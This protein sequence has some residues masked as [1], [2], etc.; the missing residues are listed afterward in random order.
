[1][2][3]EILRMEQVVKKI[4][5]AEALKELCLTIYG[6]EILGLTGL[7]G[8]GKSVIAE[9]LSGRS[10]FDRG[11]V[12]LEH[13]AAE[14]GMMIQAYRE[15]IYSV[16]VNP[17]LFT[18]LTIKE[19][20][21]LTEKAFSSSLYFPTKQQ[22]EA[23][24]E[25]ARSLNV[26]M[27]LDKDVSKLS[28][29]EAHLTAILRAYYLHSKL[30]ILDNITDRYTEE[31]FSDFERLLW[32]LKERGTS[33]LWIESM[34]ERMMPI[35]DRMV[36]LRN[37]REEGILFK[38]EYS[39]DKIEQI[40]IGDY[41]IPHMLEKS[42][43]MEKGE[44]LLAAEDLS[45]GKIEGFSFY[46]GKGEVIGFLDEE[47][48]FCEEI[49]NILGGTR[50]TVK[51]KLTLQGSQVSL[52]AGREKMIQSGFGYVDNYKNSV[53]SKLSL[54]DNLTISSLQRLKNY[55]GI[56]LRLERKVAGDLMEKLQIPSGDWKKPIKDTSN[57]VQ[58]AAALYKWVLNRSKVV[59][60]N[61][62]L[63]G[64]DVIMQDIIRHFL[65][66]LKEKGNGAIILAYNA[67]ELCEMCDRVYVL[68]HGRVTD[69]RERG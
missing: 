7:S 25:A 6:G 39:T 43:P 31:E 52:Q 15:G 42:I 58:L 29:Y 54:R 24:K 20:I 60:L 28:A 36:I 19:N 64:T 56:N 55:V 5:G 35:A 32:R 38:G 46:L 61:H 50:E 37:G 34:A 69:I 22:L 63:S 53:F 44:K 18:C 16:T 51:G 67:R 57:R 26:T 13:S 23:V 11:R 41:A 14:P 9:I 49:W 1:M 3:K 33:I 27:D 65:N 2:R 59:I 48:V 45:Y 47:K 30:I 17:A 10:T 68:G 8:S 4:N 21:C 12:L 66:E 62:V 40:M